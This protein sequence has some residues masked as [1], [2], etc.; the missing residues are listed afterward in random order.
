[1]LASGTTRGSAEKTPSTSVKISQTSA[2]SAAA[3]AT[4]V[5]SDPPRPRVVTSLVS[6]LTPWKPATIGIA[7]S[8][9]DCWIRPGV[10]SMIRAAP[11]EASVIRPAWEPVKDCAS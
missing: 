2:P 6:R 4:A 7:P 3:R 11:W 5:V 8:S 9:S 1:M 10:K